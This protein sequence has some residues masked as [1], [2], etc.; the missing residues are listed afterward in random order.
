MCCECVQAIRQQ[1]TGSGVWGGARRSQGQQASASGNRRSLTKRMSRSSGVGRVYYGD[2][3]GGSF[4]SAVSQDG[5]SVMASTWMPAQRLSFQSPPVQGGRR[6]QRTTSLSDTGGGAMSL[7]KT[8]PAGRVARHRRTR[9]R[10][11]LTTSIG[12]ST[13]NSKPRQSRGPRHR[14]RK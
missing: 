7:N 8:A 14:K 9:S 4:S 5:S 12:S 6:R 1:Q 13:F 11:S 2:V 3:T 10:L